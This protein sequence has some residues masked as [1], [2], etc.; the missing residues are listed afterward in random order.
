MNPEGL[1]DLRGEQPC[2]QPSL[3]QAEARRLP[4]DPQTHAAWM[5]V[6]IPALPAPLDGA[7]PAGSPQV[8]GFSPKLM[9]N[10]GTGTL[11]DLCYAR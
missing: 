4:P 6:A 8:R 7:D 11:R 5:G 1:R 9:E 3:S 10:T 2:Q